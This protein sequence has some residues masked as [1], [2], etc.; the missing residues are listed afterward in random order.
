MMGEREKGYVKTKRCCG[1]IKKVFSHG[2]ARLGTSERGSLEGRTDW[3]ELCSL[4]I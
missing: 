4:K 3:R 1:G 2:L